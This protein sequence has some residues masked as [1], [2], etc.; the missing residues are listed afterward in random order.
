MNAKEVRIGNLVSN[1]D[2]TL[3]GIPVGTPH[4]LELED[5][6]FIEFYVPIPITKKILSSFGL[7]ANSLIWVIND[8]YWCWSEHSS[9]KLKFY[10]INGSDWIC[11]VNHQDLCEIKYVHQLQNI[12][13]A[14][15]N[16]ELELK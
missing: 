9:S 10:T 7:N 3:K 12:Y 16:E 15:Y 5:F 6:K 2:G 13:Y 1:Q 14:I 8:D 4:K 11:R